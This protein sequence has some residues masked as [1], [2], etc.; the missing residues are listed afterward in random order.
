MSVTLVLWQRPWFYDSDP[1][2]MTAT[3]V[4]W[5]RPWFYDS[6]PGSMTATLVLWQRP[7]FY[8]SHWVFVSTLGHP[9]DY[10]ILDMYPYKILLDFLLSKLLSTDVQTI[11][12][13]FFFNSVFQSY[14][15]LAFVSPV[16]Q[17]RQVYAIHRYLCFNLN[18]NLRY[19][20]TTYMLVNYSL[21]LS[22]LYKHLSPWFA[23]E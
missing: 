3:L 10:Y 5:Q 11:F 17:I 16:F 15:T 18:C 4:L 19:K 14:I 9:H 12:F 21:V 2:S 22:H 13:F 7:S 6:D 23:M 1:G 8:D 20:W